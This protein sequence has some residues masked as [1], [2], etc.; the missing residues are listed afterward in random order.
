LRRHHHCAKRARGRIKDEAVT[1]RALARDPEP[2]G[3]HNIGRAA[4]ERDLAGFG[5][6]K[7]HGLDREVELAIDAMGFDDIDLPRERAG[8]LHR[9]PNAVGGGGICRGKRDDGDQCEAQ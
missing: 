5:R 7:L 2:I 8:F 4:L 9:E 6:C 1:Q 3:K